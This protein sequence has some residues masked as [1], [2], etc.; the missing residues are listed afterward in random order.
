MQDTKVL[1]KWLVEN[2]SKWPEISEKSG[3][4]ARTLAY[5]VSGYEREFRRSTLIC[6]SNTMKSWREG[7]K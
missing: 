3:V 6:L 4:S 2:R 1:R 5:L 7:K